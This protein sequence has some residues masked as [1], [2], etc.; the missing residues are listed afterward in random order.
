MMGDMVI[1]GGGPPGCSVLFVVVCVYV[2]VADDSADSASDLD[3]LDS[4][5]KR[6]WL[7]RSSFR[8]RQCWE[9]ELE[10]RSKKGVGLMVVSFICLFKMSSCCCKKDS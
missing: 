1:L 10:E 7:F 2:F 4:R 5:F 9:F 6:A 8:C 3:C